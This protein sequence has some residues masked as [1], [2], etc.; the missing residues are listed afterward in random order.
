MHPR[1]EG[2]ERR[3]EAEDEERARA[4]QGEEREE[5]D[6]ADPASRHRNVIAARV[7]SPRLAFSRA[8]LIRSSG[9]VWL[10]T[11]DHA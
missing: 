1:R 9:N 3:T 10:T 7:T 2:R 6:V 8:S 4:V 5:E 11:V